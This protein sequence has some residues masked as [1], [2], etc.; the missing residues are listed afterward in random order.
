MEIGECVC[1]E[2]E[3]RVEDGEDVG[4]EGVRAA[5]EGLG[6][7]TDGVQKLGRG[8]ARG[9]AEDVVFGYLRG[10]DLVSCFGVGV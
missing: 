4:D 3:A 1:W 8:Q 10:N 6:D 9:Q 5:D 7:G 2:A